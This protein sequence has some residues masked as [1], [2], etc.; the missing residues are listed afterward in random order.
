M[1]YDETSEHK[2]ILRFHQIYCVYCQKNQ[3]WKSKNQQQQT[4]EAEITNVESD[5]ES[6]CED[7]ESQF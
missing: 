3:N 7:C 2:Q 5:S 4:F 6:D 1:T